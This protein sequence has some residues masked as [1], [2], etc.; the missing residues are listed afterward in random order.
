MKK[1]YSILA[2]LAFVW[3][4][5]A[6]GIVADNVSI[7]KG[8][9]AVVS[10]NYEFNENNN[11]VYVGYVFN[12]VMPEGIT[13]LKDA[14]GN[15]VYN[16]DSQNSSF[17]I[18]STADGGFGAF[19]QTTTS[20]STLKGKSGSLLSVTFIADPNLEVGTEHTV[21]ITNIKLSRRESNGD[22]TTVEYDD[23]TFKVTIVDNLVILDET[24]TTDPEPIEGVNVQVK[25]TI[26]ADEWST[27]C[28]PFGM[29][30]DQVKSIFGD[31]VKL[32]DFTGCDATK[33]GDDITSIKVNFASVSAI[34]AHHPYIIRTS[35]PLS[36]FTIN[37]VDITESTNL[38]INKDKITQIFDLGNG[39][40]IEMIR[41][42]QFIGTYKANTLLT[43]KN[44]LFL[45]GNKFWYSNGNINMKAFRGYFYFHVVLK[46]KDA[47]SNISFAFD[48]ADGIN[49]VTM[50]Q[51][52]EGIYDIQGRKVHTDEN[53]W[54]NL[55]KGVYIING[56]KVV[57]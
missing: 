36:E 13:L 48:E 49:N 28:L 25:R 34:E 26:N 30:E 8:N 55:K 31:D 17:N 57:K 53:K 14:E 40:T 47:N 52:A 2:F 21:K 41:Y 1:I 10:I 9:Q 20:T 46:N 45:N 24:S 35:K 3:Q 11:D 29:N 39:E 18:T 22:F 37:N 23:F 12:L 56:K 6:E 33:T 15:V 43:N 50:G 4:A 5:N 38:T 42:N 32:G 27:L 16:L 7:M 19:P 44:Y 51:P 54:D